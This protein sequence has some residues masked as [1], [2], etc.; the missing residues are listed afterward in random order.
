MEQICHPCVAGKMRILSLPLKMPRP[1]RV[2]NWV[3]MDMCDLPRGGHFGAV[4]D[5]ATRFATV[6]L[7]A[8][9]SDAATSIAVH[10]VV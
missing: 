2:M 8:R 3:D 4:I 7:L 10:H 5:E 9:K 6:T 1:V